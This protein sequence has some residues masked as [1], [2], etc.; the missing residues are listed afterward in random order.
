MPNAEPYSVAWDRSNATAGIGKVV[1]PCAFVVA[2]DTRSPVLPVSLRGTRE[3]LVA[4]GLRSRRGAR[5]VVTI[6][7]ALG[8]EPYASMSPKA[9][10]EALLEDARASIAR[11]L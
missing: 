9:G 5:V 11:G 3:A 7:P 8:P 10:R 1:A 2:L 6:H 4:R